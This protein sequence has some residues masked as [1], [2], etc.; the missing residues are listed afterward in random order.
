VSMP[1]T[2]NR[3]RMSRLGERRI[4]SPPRASA[5]FVRRDER[6]QSG[7]VHELQLGQ[8]DRDMTHASPR[9][10]GQLL[11]QL[12]DVGGIE[13]AREHHEGMLRFSLAN[14]GSEDS[15]AR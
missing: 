12:R 7:R 1:V 4:S 10:V 11:M 13:L 3:R 14:L 5:R 8:V 6:R 15:I 9:Q 2:S